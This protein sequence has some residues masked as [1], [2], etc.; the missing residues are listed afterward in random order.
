MSWTFFS[1]T[2]GN[3]TGAVGGSPP[4]VPVLAATDNGN[5]TGAVATISGSTA[6]TANTVYAQFVNG[7]LGTST[8]TS[9]G[10][11]IGDGTV[12]LSLAVGYWWLKVESTSAFG[13]ATSNLVYLAVT[14]GTL[15]LWER[16]LTAAQARIQTLSLSGVPS[17]NVLVRKVLTDRDVGAGKTYQF[18]VIQL[19]P[20]PR[21]S[22]NPTLGTTERDDVSYPVLVAMI[23]PDPQHNHT[24]NRARNLL[25]REKIAKAF[26]NQ[27]LAGLTEIYTCAVEPSSIIH[28]ANWLESALYTSFLVIRFTS[29]ETRGL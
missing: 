2:F 8:W 3:N 15:A 1:R 14:S 29:R 20:G 11:R 17:G 21:E 7:E 19:A 16:I 5:G 12:S 26:R 27:K 25:W 10:S 28:P 4:A 6:G 13:S 9:Y 18:P 23:D 24:T 22:M